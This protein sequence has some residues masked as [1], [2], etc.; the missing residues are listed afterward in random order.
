MLQSEQLI[1]GHW[2]AGALHAALAV[3][4]LVIFALPKYQDNGWVAA[5]RTTATAATAEER[6]NYAVGIERVGRIP[7]QWLLL[8]FA[9]ITS[10]F[11]FMNAKMKTGLLGTGNPLRWLE[12]SMSAPIMLVIIAALAGVRTVDTLVV[13][14]FATCVTMYFG[15]LVE[16]SGSTTSKFM[17]TA[18]GW[19][20]Y[21]PVWAMI[22]YVFGTHVRDAKD[23]NADPPGWLWSVVIVEFLL[24]SAFGF[25][26]L[27][28]VMYPRKISS[29]AMEW[30][31][32]GL[33]FTSKALLVGL[34]CYG[35]TQ[36]VS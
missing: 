1:R 13:M 20:L 33:S 14:A 34:L 31:Y 7:L 26:Q 2:A 22:F 32:M 24:F 11:H 35:L 10:V 9:V 18:A 17:N 4:V 15:H 23:S 8:T 6:M 12:Y 28:K 36:T 30:T 19:T 16:T 29:F 3:T 5:Y 25:A 21:L 27:L